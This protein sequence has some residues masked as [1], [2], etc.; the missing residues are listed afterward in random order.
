MKETKNTKVF[1]LDIDSSLSWK[2]HI[3]QIMIKLNRACY[4]IRYDTHSTLKPVQLFHD[5]WR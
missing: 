1:G 2:K 3:D 4:A 5:S